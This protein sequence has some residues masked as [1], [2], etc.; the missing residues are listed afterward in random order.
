ME[1]NTSNGHGTHSPDGD[2]SPL[3]LRGSLYA[4]ATDTPLTSW[5]DVHDKSC[6]IIKGSWMIIC[7]DVCSKDFYMSPASPLD[8]QPQIYYG[9]GKNLVCR[10]CLKME[11]GMLSVTERWNNIGLE[12]SE[13]SLMLYSSAGKPVESVTPFLIPSSGCAHFTSQDTADTADTAGQLSLGIDTDILHLTPSA[14]STLLDYPKNEWAND[15][16]AFQG[17]SNTSQIEWK[18]T[19][20]S[21]VEVL[22]HKGSDSGTEN[23]LE[24]LRSLE[25]QA[26]SA[27]C[28]LAYSAANVYKKTISQGSVISSSNYDDKYQTAPKSPS[29]DQ[30]DHDRSTSVKE[31]Q[32]FHEIKLALGFHP[33]QTEHSCRECGHL[34]FHATCG[35]CGTSHELDQ[36][37]A[38]FEPFQQ[39]SDVVDEDLFERCA[40]GDGLGYNGCCYRCDEPIVPLQN[41]HLIK[42]M[43]VPIPW[44]TWQHHP[45]CYGESIN[46]V[47]TCRCPAC[48]SLGYYG[49]CWH[50]GFGMGWFDTDTIRPGY[51]AASAFY[52]S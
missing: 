5:K 18:V 30:S 21:K 20:T 48:G 7:C 38:Q 1:A 16:Y 32:S 50:C 23:W 46:Q 45:V 6:S 4:Q 37:P 33:H 17:L 34:G 26:A 31:N 43:P 9:L 19:R 27:Y 40:S 13:S 15:S 14:A 52:M 35:Y 11:M 36:P 2:V 10:S 25:R 44:V 28:T 29:G 24:D 51:S 42:S 12:R 22:D 3:Q 47:D 8:Y 39:A 41:Q 49:T